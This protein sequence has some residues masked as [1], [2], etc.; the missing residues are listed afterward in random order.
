M[1]SYYVSFD[2]P[3]NFDLLNPD[4]STLSSQHM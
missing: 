3:L 1:L 4:I 2:V